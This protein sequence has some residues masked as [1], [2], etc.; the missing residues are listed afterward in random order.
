MKTALPAVI[1]FASCSLL[2]RPRVMLI[3]TLLMV[4][5]LLLGLMLLG[6]GTPSGLSGVSVYPGY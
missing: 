3:G 6:V 5:T 4:L 1:R 2:W